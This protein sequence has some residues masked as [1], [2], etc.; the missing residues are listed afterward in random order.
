M[1]Q[2]T[3]LATLPNPNLKANECHEQ[4]MTLGLI[5]SETSAGREG[6]QSYGPKHRTRKSSARRLR[7]LTAHSLICLVA[8][9]A[10]RDR[11]GDV[12]LLPG[13]PLPTSYGED[14]YRLK[15]GAAPN[16]TAVGAP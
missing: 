3:Y 16:A 6:L 13:E 5:H 2:T 11:G 4:L 14:L 7:A 9:G 1:K 8:N 15:F 12:R 10:G